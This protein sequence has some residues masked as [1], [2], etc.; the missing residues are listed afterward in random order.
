MHNQHLTD[1]MLIMHV[2]YHPNIA[3]YYIY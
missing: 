3:F 2:L 1:E